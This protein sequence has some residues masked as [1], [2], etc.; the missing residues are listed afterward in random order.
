MKLGVFFIAIGAVSLIVF[1][2]FLIMSLI[3]SD[4]M[5]V[6]WMIIYTTLGSGGF[7]YEGI[8]RVKRVRR[9]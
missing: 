3:M 5:G 6:V 4:Y 7:L 8:K 2:Q 9:E 1:V